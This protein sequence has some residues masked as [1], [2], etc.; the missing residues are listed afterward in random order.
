MGGKGILINGSFSYCDKN[1]G[2]ISVS[3][4]LAMIVDPEILGVNRTHYIKRPHYVRFNT[5]FCEAVPPK[6]NYTGLDDL[7]EKYVVSIDPD[8]KGQK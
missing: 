7:F 2:G 3:S 4:P 5:E 1:G 6:V 8:F